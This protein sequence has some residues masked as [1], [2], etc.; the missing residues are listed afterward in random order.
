MTQGTSGDDVIHGSDNDDEIYGRSGNDV[1]FGGGGNDE[2]YG[3]SGNDY[4][5]GE[6]GLDVIYG[7]D[8]NDVLSAHQGGND[9]LFGGNG[10]DL[11]YVIRT[12]DSITEGF[13]QGID[14]VSSSVTY[15]LSQSNADLENLVLTGAT[16]IHGTGNDLDNQ[17][18]GNSGNNILIGYDGNDTLS[19]LGGDDALLG[20]K[21][22]D[23]LTGGT[24][25]DQFVFGF[26]SSL[27]AA[28]VDT[29]TDFEVFTGD[30]V[31]LHKSIFSS[32]ETGAGSPVTGGSLLDG[33]D[34]STINVPAASEVAIAGS[35]LNE[36]V[37]N[38][39]T[40][41]LFY[42]P[43]NNLSGFGEGGGQFATIVGSSDYF[44]NA[45]IRVI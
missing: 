21:G 20:E 3:G 36:I 38:F 40:G 19:G 7:G 42:N 9:Q 16:N 31:L 12:T 30:T 2:I 29:I 43:N 34:F 18:T 13:N 28:G 14:T 35:S 4:I 10:N 15:D 23:I 8:G 37:Y 5:F 26:L 45:N 33:G 41:S 1:L 24:G 27:P 25:K 17:I 22:N 32:L 6:E 11:Y 39:M 44:S